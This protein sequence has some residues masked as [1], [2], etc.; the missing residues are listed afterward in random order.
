VVDDHELARLLSFVLQRQ[1]Y[2]VELAANGRE[3]WER[4]RCGRL[5]WCSIGGLLA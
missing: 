2:P 5:R 4:V 1:R 3:A